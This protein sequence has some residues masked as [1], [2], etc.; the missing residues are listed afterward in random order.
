[1][2]GEGDEKLLV[3][4]QSVDDAGVVELEHNTGAPTDTLL[5]QTVDY[6]PPVVDD[7]RA[8]GRIAAANA[9]S[10]V[11]A[12]GGR[13]YS[14][15]NLAGFPRDFSD[16]WIGEILA[17]GFSA[18]EEAGCVVAGGHTTQSE[19]CLFGFAVTGMV[20]RQRL[21][22]NAGAKVGDALYLTKPLGMGTMSTASKR[23]A[24]DADAMQPAIE[25]MATLNRAAAEAMATV[26]AHACTDVTG[27]GLAGHARNIGKASGVTLTIDL[28][29]VP[30]FKGAHA[31]ASEGF[32]SGGATRGRSALGEEVSVADGLDE[33]LVSMAY[34][35]ETSGGLL[36][37][38]AEADAAALEAALTDRGVLAVRVGSV[39]EA[40]GPAVQLA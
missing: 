40:A 5:V 14:A 18:M 32:C 27:F 7:A 3:G 1:V 20:E 2:I 37:A 34:D 39:T 26:D 12:M 36:I 38:L 23:G 6:F 15:L 10:D 8:Y 30:L 11:Y 29:N 22:T 31:L 21:V 4:P 16:E 24:V 13:A 28:A 33:A 35:A 25:Q 19:E 17:G 9:L